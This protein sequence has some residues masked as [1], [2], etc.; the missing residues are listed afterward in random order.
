MK[1]TP[2][3]WIYT[4]EESKRYDEQTGEPRLV[5][6]DWIQ[7]GK[8]HR[9]PTFPVPQTICGLMTSSCTV[10]ETKANGALI[11]ASPTMKSALETVLFGLTD[12]VTNNNGKVD[13]DGLIKT[14]KTALAKA[15]GI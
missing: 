1:H 8:T 12:D 10:E 15:E 6:F 5:S 9:Y 2:G 13:F 3:P 14:V 11:A 7:C 4:R